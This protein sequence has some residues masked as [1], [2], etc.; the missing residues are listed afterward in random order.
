MSVVKFAF[1]HQKHTKGKLSQNKRKHQQIAPKI[2]FLLYWFFGLQWFLQYFLAMWSIRGN[3]Q[4]PL[5]ALMSACFR[6]NFDWTVHEEKLPQIY[7][8]F[9]LVHLYREVTGS[10]PVEVLT[11]SGF[12]IRNCINCFRNSEDH[13]LL[14][15]T[16]AVQHMKY[17]IHIFKFS[18]DA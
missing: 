14:D 12:Y 13:S 16:S 11:F 7:K 10:N 4:L 3:M 9:W 17:F 18:Y 6:S 15:F 8:S 1:A 5:I 2:L